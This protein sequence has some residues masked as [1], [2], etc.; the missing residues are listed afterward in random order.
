MDDHKPFRW[1]IARSEQLPTMTWRLDYSEYWPSYEI[2]LRRCAARVIAAAADTDWVF[3]GRSPEN[4]FDYPSGI[5]AGVPDA[6]SLTQLLVSLRG[7]APETVAREEP[8]A[9]AALGSYFAAERLDPVSIATYGKAVTFI[10]VVS[11]GHTFGKRG[12]VPAHLGTPGRRRLERGAAPA[13]LR[14]AD[15]AP[16][17]EP[18]HLA[19]A[20]A[21]VLARPGAGCR[22]AQRI[23]AASGAQ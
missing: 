6:P 8:G 9:L 18:K 20:A 22:G 4:L 14:R 7:S 5:F 21:P 17:D 2:E 11:S 19:L 12:G 23:R 1:D 15:A 10:D 13:A 16:Q 3:V